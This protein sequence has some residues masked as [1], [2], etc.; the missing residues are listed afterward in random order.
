MSRDLST[1]LALA[2]TVRAPRQPRMTDDS[3]TGRE[4][5]ARP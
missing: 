4:D 5:L 2:L 3:S 1:V